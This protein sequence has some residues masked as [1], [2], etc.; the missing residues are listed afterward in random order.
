VAVVAAPVIE[1]EQGMDHR[2]YAL[3]VFTLP[4]LLGM[5]L[6][7]T[8]SVLSDRWPRRRVLRWSLL[9]LG[10]ALAACGLA[11]QMWLLSLGLALAGS[12][13]GVA[14]GVAKAELVAVPEAAERNIGTPPL[15]AAMLALG[16]S[17]RGALLACA[18]VTLLQ[19][20]TLGRASEPAPRPE[21]HAPL[22]H[23]LREA[24]GNPTLWRWLFG[25]AMCTL[26][27]E[28][29]FAFASLRME[30]DLRFTPELAAAC[31]TAVSI[32]SAVGAAATERLLPRWHST[33]LLRAS[34]ALSIAALALSIAA[35]GLLLLLPA[36]LL[37][38]LAAA[39]QYALLEAR[40]YAALPERPGV[41][42]AASQ[43]FSLLEVTAPLLV[44]LIADRFGL[45]AAL[46][47]LTLQ[48]L[49]VLMLLL[50]DTARRRTS[51]PSP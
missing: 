15:V 2:Q 48:P 10:L 36:L 3:L 40:A 22:R 9:A 38:G 49:S 8:L 42:N 7:P 47:T 46:A 17:Y 44:G 13:S 26:L 33:R 39:P 1:A 28:I 29:L 37:L 6:E 30:R 45:A 16:G 19:A 32:G 35:H 5:L 14:C 31:A 11:R 21:A 50:G 4:L 23:A 24:L 43:A 51:T 27:D 20:A 12:A 41:V 18:A 34:A 25:A